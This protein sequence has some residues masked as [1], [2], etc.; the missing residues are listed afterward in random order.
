MYSPIQIHRPQ[1]RNTQISGEHRVATMTFLLVEVLVLLNLYLPL[2]ET[3]AF[4]N[5]NL[6]WWINKHILQINY[7]HNLH[8]SSHTAVL[9]FDGSSRSIPYQNSRIVYG[10]RTIMAKIHRFTILIPFRKLHGFY[11]QWFRVRQTRAVVAKSRREAT[12]KV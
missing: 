5:E 9:D 7:K 11:Y 10:V 8:V 1:I 2:V 4:A 6:V 3:V 12:V